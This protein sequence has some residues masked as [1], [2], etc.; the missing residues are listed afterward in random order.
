MS[1]KPRMLDLFAGRLGW[2]KAFLARGW[3]CVAVDLVEPPEIP[4]GVVF[5]KRNVLEISP[6]C[7]LLNEKHFDFIFASSPCEEFSVHGMKHLHPN[8][9]YPENGIKL[10][11]HTR[12]LCEASGVP[13]VIENVRAAQQF[14]GTAVHHC[15]AFYLWGSGVPPILPRGAKKGFQTGGQIIQKLKAI[16]SQALTEYRRQND[17]SWS[18]SG[19]AKRKEF[20]AIAASIPPELAFCV[21]DYAGRLLE[22]R[23][24]VNS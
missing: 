4:S 7:W 11:N 13:Y 8:P 22:Q 5:L 10:F 16:D 17:L 24:E 20:T 23:R 2:T 3:E 19:S 21:C 18:S 1:L 14:V 12:S 15:A 6:N 9:K